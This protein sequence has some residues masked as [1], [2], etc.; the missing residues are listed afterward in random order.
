MTQPGSLAL[1]DAQD[2]RAIRRE[3][4][5]ADTVAA[6]LRQLQQQLTR[7]LTAAYLT[8][9]GSLDQRPTED[10]SL[11]LR[12]AATALMVEF[13][14]RA[15]EAVTR[16]IQALTD[17][18]LAAVDFGA[19]LAEQWLG[20]PVD[21]LNHLDPG[22]AQAIADLRQRAGT[23]LADAAAFAQNMP[24][25]S[26][27]DMLAVAGKANRATTR[28]DQ[29]ARWVFNRGANRGVELVALQLGAEKL[30]IAERDACLTCLAYSGDTAGAT[31][32]FPAGKTYG[33]KSTVRWPIPGPPAHPNCRCRLQV[34]LGS[35]AEVG[36]VEMPEALRREAQRTVARG[37]SEYASEPA[38]V[39][40]ATR[41]LGQ[42]ATLLPRSVLDRARMAVAAGRFRE[43]KL[44]DLR[45]VR[46]RVPRV[47]RVPP[48][49]RPHIQ[50]AR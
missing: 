45:P 46:G 20:Q 7:D 1:L 30:W 27:G 4:R 22:M 35:E 26:H 34:W 2:L 25:R 48:W 8:T 37:W 6:P 39:R 44:A 17:A 38:R 15:M 32:L 13:I 47:Q 41:L 28:S 23:D 43:P 50:R 16:V 14:A 40:A 19:R 49:G 9:V 24:M 12:A 29:T 31:E 11:L 5:T 33:D 3:N 42:G 18:A 36:P 21:Q 10:Q